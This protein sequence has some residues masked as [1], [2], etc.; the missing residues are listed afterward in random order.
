M[1]E[2]IVMISNLRIKEGK[3]EEYK[4]FTR[5][6]TEW[7]QANRPGTTAILEYV[8]EDGTDLSVVLIFSNAEAMQAHMQGLGE[9]PDKS[10]ELAQVESIQIYGKPNE[11]TLEMM[12]MIGGAGI[13]FNIKPQRIG[14]YI[15]LSSG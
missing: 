3:L 7:L 5:E 14:G 9:F 13:T 8:S 11:T 4:K 6:A 10:R 12:K 2:P 15:R 1:S